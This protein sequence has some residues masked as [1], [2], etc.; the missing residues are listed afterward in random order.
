MR[1]EEKALCAQTDPEIFFPDTAT[2]RRAAKMVCN[3]N[4]MNIA[5]CP[6]RLMCLEDAVDSDERHGVRGGMTEKERR[7]LRGA[8]T[9]QGI[10]VHLP[11]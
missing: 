4:G 8:K 1:W 10:A 5:P 6:V 9:M 3:G 7:K 2:E 11:S